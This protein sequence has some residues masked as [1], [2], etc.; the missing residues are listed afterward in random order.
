MLPNDDDSRIA[1]VSNKWFILSDDFL[2][3]CSS[4][5]FF[6]F[7]N[8]FLIDFRSKSRSWASSL[9]FRA[10]SSTVRPNFVEIAPRRWVCSAAALQ[11]SEHELRIWVC[12]ATA[13]WSGCRGAVA[14]FLKFLSLCSFYA[15]S[16]SFVPV[17]TIRPQIII[18]FSF[19]CNCLGVLIT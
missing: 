4:L 3:F 1:S 17:M 6:L 8:A 16:C 7:S 11:Y 18:F 14:F 2:V 9:R 12:S 13:L 15:P 19:S 10:F 5:P